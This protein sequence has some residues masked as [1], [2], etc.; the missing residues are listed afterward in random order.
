M[1]GRRPTAAWKR[2]PTGTELEALID[3][4]VRDE[5][6]YR[7]ALA[8]GMD[9]NDTVIRRRMRQKMEFLSGQ[10]GI[11]FGLFVWSVGSGRNRYL[12]TG[13]EFPY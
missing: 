8:L 12:H 10:R 3:G 6:Y 2:Q 1:F 5:V 11:G 7:E 13:S 4:D 9:R